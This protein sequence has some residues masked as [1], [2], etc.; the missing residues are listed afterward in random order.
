MNTNDRKT[1]S[2]SVPPASVDPASV[3][4]G[5]HGAR[6]NEPIILELHR[7]GER[8][9]IVPQAEPELIQSFGPAAGLVPEGL[10]RKVA[11]ALPEISEVRVLRHYIRLSQE[12]MGADSALS[13]GLGT[14]TMKYNPKIN[15]SFVRNPKMLELHPWQDEQTVQGILGIIH[16]TDHFLRGISGMDRFSFQPSSGS[17]AIYANASIVRAWHRHN[18]QD[19]Q[20]DEVITTIFS[21]P[22]NAG[23]PSTAGYKVLTLMPDADGYPDLEQLRRL[24]GPRTAALF[25][26]NPEDTGIFNPRIKDCVDLVHAAGGLCVYDQANANGLLGITRAREAGFDL[27]HFNLHKTF[28]SPHGSMGPGCG[29]LGATEKLAAYLP[30]PTVEEKDGRYYLDYHREHSIGKVRKFHGVVPVVLRTYAYIMNLGEQGLRK[31]AEL[32]V[33]NNN[34]MLKKLL[35]IPG[36]SVPY[37]KDDHKLEQVRY[38][39]ENLTKET[40]VDSDAI[41][42][43]TVDYG[44]QDYFASHH[45]RIVPEPFTPEPCET[46]SR[47]DIDEYVGV[48]RNIAAEARSAP[49]LVIS[50]PHRSSIDRVVDESPMEDMEK[51]AV[52]W[53]AYKRKRAAG[54]YDRTPVASATDATP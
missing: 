35:E 25:I 5:F 49:G 13:I 2:A 24:V 12:T 32:S 17:Q 53:R 18:G 10:R 42:R 6:W 33:L 28:A 16:K 7:P 40:G 26:T 45:P 37:A 27:M 14:C 9:I 38:S 43:R 36:I 54:V 30:V 23:A 19:A 22:G 4:T 20:R 44:M 50:A 1:P 47:D 8:G 52:T 3:P 21:H 15:E 29:A 41:N 34:Y 46:Y 31:A 39:W 48:F 51:F 11:P